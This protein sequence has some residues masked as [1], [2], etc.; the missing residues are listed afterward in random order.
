MYDAVIFTDEQITNI[1]YKDVEWGKISAKK[2]VYI[3][4]YKENLITKLS[5][6]I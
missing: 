2:D 6:I 3:S 4:E 1:R 5:I